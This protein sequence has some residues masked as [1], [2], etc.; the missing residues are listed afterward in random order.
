MRPRSASTS[1]LLP[2]I[3][4]PFA[5]LYAALKSSS[6]ANSTKAYPLGFPSLSSTTRTDRTSPN[7]IA[8]ALGPNPTYA[9]FSP[10]PTGHFDLDSNHVRL[11]D[12]A[13]VDPTRKLKS[14]EDF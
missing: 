10:S 9:K 12:T 11:T 1:T 5:D 4:R 6:R 3:L 14:D 7:L 13:V 2:S 8:D